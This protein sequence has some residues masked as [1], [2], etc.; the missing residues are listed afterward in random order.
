M[1]VEGIPQREEVM[2]F[3][4]HYHSYFPGERACFTPEE[5]QALAALGVASPS[6]GA[7]LTGGAFDQAT[8]DSLLA[9]LAGVPDGG[10]LISINGPPQRLMRGDFTAVLTGADVVARINA[11]LGTW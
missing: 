8:F 7:T 11:S 6:T 4:A 10:F 5:A 1:V 9:A 3:S 2:V